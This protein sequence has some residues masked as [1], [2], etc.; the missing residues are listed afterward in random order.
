[1]GKVFELLAKASHPPT[2]L[3]LENVPFMLQLDRGRAMRFLTEQL[4][5]LGYRWA[6][7][8]VDTR[9]FGLPQRRQRV[10]LLASPVE[11]PR[12]VV[13]AEDIGAP[14]PPDLAGHA[15][16]FYWTEGTRGL[17]WAIDAVPTLKGGS[18]VGIPSPP[19][20][21][22]SHDGGI[23][24]PDIRD[25]ERLQGFDSGWTEAAVPATPTRRG[26]RWRLIGN[27]VSVPVAKWLGTWL[28]APGSVEL[29]DVGILQDGDP[30]PRA[31]WGEC[32]KAYRVD[33]SAWPV[34]EEYQSLKEF[35]EHPTAPLSYRA[36]AGFLRRAEE[37]SLRFE[38]AFLADVRAHRDRMALRTAVA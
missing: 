15:C 24:T 11:D 35:L 7:R 37:S 26:P 36:T 21:W 33:A 32:R 3:L 38:R 25:A 8:V 22:R 4:D 29:K 5:E 17:G 13:F 18:T 12:E 2:W 19:A 31:A 28:A 1:V 16:G 30:W 6:Y 14:D 10:L 34:R 23:V 20:I 9:A 27:A